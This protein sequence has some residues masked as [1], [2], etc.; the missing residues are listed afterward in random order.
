[1]YGQYLT[2]AA[3]EQ[4][5][6]QGTA[7]GFSLTSLLESTKKS[8]SQRR[9]GRGSSSTNKAVR[10]G[11]TARGGAAQPAVRRLLTMHFRAPF[12]LTTL[13]SLVTG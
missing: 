7:D 1:M 2:P 12:G 10:P 4:E 5:P 11:V 3:E 13:I 6:D 9:L 8:K